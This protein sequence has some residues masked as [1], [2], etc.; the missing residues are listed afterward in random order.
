MINE[1]SSM[2]VR[3][4]CKFGSGRAEIEP[5]EPLRI[6][7]DKVCARWPNIDRDSIEICDSSNHRDSKKWID[8]AE[9]SIGSLEKRYNT[10]C[11]L[12]QIDCSIF[13]LAAL[14]FQA[15]V[16]YL[17]RLAPLYLCLA[18]ISE[19]EESSMNKHI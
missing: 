13:R 8:F 12:V 10:K 15:A 14:Y 11:S 18:T 9:N 4:R 5:D 3:F 19:K 2:I 17:L 6:L 7:I 1:K 16:P